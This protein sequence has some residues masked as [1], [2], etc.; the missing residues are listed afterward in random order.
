MA[1]LKRK[2]RGGPEVM[3]AEKCK[4]CQSAPKKELRDGGGGGP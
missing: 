1:V 4:T 3:H 2:K